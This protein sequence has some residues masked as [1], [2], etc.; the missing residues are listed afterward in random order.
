[1]RMMDYL[2]DSSAII[3]HMRRKPSPLHPVLQQLQA[4]TCFICPIVV[5][6]VQVGAVLAK[7]SAAQSARVAEIL[8]QFPSIPID[9]DIA[10]IAAE[11]DAG[12]IRQNARITGNDLWIAAV[13]V[14]RKLTVITANVR[15][16]GRVAD[17]RL[18]PI[19]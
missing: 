17:L 6:E 18:L 2:I 10:R 11:I 1:M 5:A 8:S 15:H 3:L 13:A 7:D 12:L 16:F 4:S 19:S 9:D 14:S